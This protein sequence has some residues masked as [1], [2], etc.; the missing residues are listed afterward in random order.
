MSKPMFD[1]ITEPMQAALGA[2]NV[3]IA[4]IAGIEVVGGGWRVPK[5]QDLISSWFKAAGK[6]F[7]IGQH[8]NGEEAAASAATLIAANSTST[9]RVRKVFF[10]DGM[11]RTFNLEI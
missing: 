3:T 1:R 8:L 11:P 9:F 5:I 10:Q 7:D 6:M 2:A 4:D